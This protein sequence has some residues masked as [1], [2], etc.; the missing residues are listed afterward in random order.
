MK[1]SFP[2]RWIYTYVLFSAPRYIRNS[3]TS[4][5]LFLILFEK[6]KGQKIPPIFC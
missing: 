4:V 2:N 6:K 3:T 5:V 1:G